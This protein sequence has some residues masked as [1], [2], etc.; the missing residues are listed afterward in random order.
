MLKNVVLYVLLAPFDHEQ[1]DLMHRV[2]QEKKL[3][4]LPLYR[5]EIWSALYDI[6]YVLDYFPRVLLIS[7]RAYPQVQYEGGSKMRA[8][9]SNFSLVKRALQSCVRH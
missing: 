8:G 4:Q 1:S 2:F 5:L 3:E 7:D 9:S 6:P